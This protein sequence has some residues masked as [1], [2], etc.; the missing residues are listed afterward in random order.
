MSTASAACQPLL[1]NLKIAT[2]TTDDVN[3]LSVDENDAKVL[4]EI[5]LMLGRAT[6]ATT[7]TY[8]RRRAAR[9][10]VNKTVNNVNENA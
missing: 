6:A 7:K 2:R 8:W 4:Q 3:R 5:E 10:L 1:V 9:R